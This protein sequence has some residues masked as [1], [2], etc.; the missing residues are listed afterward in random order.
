MTPKDSSENRRRTPCAL[1]TQRYSN[2]M[3]NAIN[4]SLAALDS[5]I[6]VQDRII[7]TYEGMLSYCNDGEGA[8]SILV[9]LDKAQAEKARLEAEWNRLLVAAEAA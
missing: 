2:L 1:G 6:A 8:D 3:S 4:A 9:H 7:D 5:A